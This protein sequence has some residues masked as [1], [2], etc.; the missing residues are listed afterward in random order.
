MGRVISAAVVAAAAVAALGLA[1]L[2][3]SAGA[4]GVDPRAGGFAVAFGEWTVVPEAKAIRP[5]A[6][7]FVVTNRGKVAHRFR[8]RSSGDGGGD[9]RFEVRSRLLAPGES[10][11]LTVTLAPGVYDLEC[12]VE[13]G[14]GDHEERGMHALLEVR[15]DAPL[16]AAQPAATANAVRIEAFAFKP[17][18]LRVRRGATVRWTNRDAAPHTVT[19]AAGSFS[20]KELGRG[21]SYAR[22]FTRAGSFA[23]LCAIHP[24]M[25]GRVVVR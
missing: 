21:G 17:S 19:A 14:Y 23:Y 10:T 5:G 8:I 1:Q 18:T 2:T 6:V 25:K 22:K 9:D 20:S 16:V 12:S 13:D 4:A 15:A 11:R 24:Q 7:T 3:G